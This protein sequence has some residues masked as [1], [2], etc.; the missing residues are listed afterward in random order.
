M[1]YTTQADLEARFG[2]SEILQLADRD[3]NGVIDAGVISLTLADTDAEID[4][5][6]SG[7]Y[8]LPLS[9]VPANLARI[10]CDI[11]RYR[12]WKD[13]ASEEVRQRYAD[14]VRY[15]EKL[16]SGAISLGPDVSGDAQ[17]ANGGIAYSV[18]ESAF[19]DTVLAAL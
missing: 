2:A 13:M 6:L 14:A 15:L 11:A 4:G 9:P 10:A 8:S 16:A 12:L 19:G 5:Y 17:P 7:R 3:G 1:S 18:P